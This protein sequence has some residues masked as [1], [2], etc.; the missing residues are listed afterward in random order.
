MPLWTT[1]TLAELRAAT[2]REIIEDV[3]RYIFDHFTKLQICKWLLDVELIQDTVGVTRDE[4]GRI[5]KRLQVWRH[6][7][8]GAVDHNNETTYTYYPNGDIED[9]TIIERD[10]DDNITEQ[11]TI[12][13]YQ[14]GRQPI[15]IEG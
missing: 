5:V 14:D 6:I 13:H 3:G 8:T 7:V 11:Y 10:G 9:I 1:M 2:K 15:R 12:H 4:A